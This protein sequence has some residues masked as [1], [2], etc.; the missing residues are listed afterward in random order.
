MRAS[1]AR[2]RAILSRLSDAHD[3]TVV[4]VGVFHGRLSRELLRLRRD[5]RLVMVD[6]WRPG[7][8]QPKRY[9]ATGDRCA[10]MTDDEA[11]A[12]RAQAEAV[13]ALYP[14]RVQI[15]EMRSTAAARAFHQ[16]G[17]EMADLVFLDADH[18]RAGLAADIKA[19]LPRCRSWIGGHD[20]GND[21]VPEFDFTGVA[22]AVHEAFG[23]GVELDANYTWFARVENGAPLTAA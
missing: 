13:A 10:T 11:A 14:D 5:L 19:W 9:K 6:D 20:Y 1:E 12:A 22:E 7:A 17:Q 23:E 8:K 3:V 15:M 4:E 2:A 16:V 18:S 21:S